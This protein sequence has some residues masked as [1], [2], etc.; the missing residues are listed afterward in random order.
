MIRYCFKECGY[1]CA[2]MQINRVAC[3]EALAE[4]L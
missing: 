2:P 3:L 1:N 4:N